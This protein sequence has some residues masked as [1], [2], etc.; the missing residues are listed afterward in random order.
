MTSYQGQELVVTRWNNGSR[1]VLVSD[2]WHVSGGPDGHPDPRRRG[3]VQQPALPVLRYRRPGARGRPRGHRPAAAAARD[4]LRRGVRGN[5]L[6]GQPDRPG[7][8]GLAGGRQPRREVLARR[9][10]QAAARAAGLRL[11]RPRDRPG[12]VHR[13]QLREPGDV[14]SAQ[15]SAAASG[16]GAISADPQGPWT[17][18]LSH[19]Q[20]LALRARG[21]LVPSELPGG[22]SLFTGAETEASTGTVLDL[23]YSDGLSVVSVFEQRGHLAAKLAGWRKTTVDGHVIFVAEPDQRSLTWSSRGMVYTVMADAPA[24][25]GRRGGRRAAAR[26]AA[27]V[28]EAHVAG[29]GPA[30]VLGQSVPLTRRKALVSRCRGT[31]AVHGWRRHGLQWTACVAPARRRA[32]RCSTCPSPSC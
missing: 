24:R 14:G 25:H 15:A 2:I 31:G 16:A 1:S 5:G 13:R 28:L 27:G 17:D 26:P 22:L 32:E 20:L 10:D 4:A 19:A 9:R 30:G 8:G 6:G 23:G 7:G 21:W 11:G 3:L 12:R 18:P 29:H